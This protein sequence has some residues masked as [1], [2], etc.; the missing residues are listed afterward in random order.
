MKQLKPFLGPS[1]LGLMHKL[2]RVVRHLF[3]EDGAQAME[4]R[5]DSAVFGKAAGG[6]AEQL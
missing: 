2:P 5:S 3:Q 6:E 4:E 1:D